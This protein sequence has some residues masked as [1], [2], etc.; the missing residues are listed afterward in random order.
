MLCGTWG[1]TAMHLHYIDQVIGL[2]EGA[3]DLRLHERA[4]PART[5]R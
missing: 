4:D 3:N 5:G 2:R 1:T